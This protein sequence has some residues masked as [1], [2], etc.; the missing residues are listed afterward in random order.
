MSPQ[1]EGHYTILNEW[2]P[3]KKSTEIWT[4]QLGDVTVAENVHENILTLD[5]FNAI[6]TGII[7]SVLI[8]VFS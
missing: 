4:V 8:Y 3:Q 6:L 5:N 2:N 7:S 1:F